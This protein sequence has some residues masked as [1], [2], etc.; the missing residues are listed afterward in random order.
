MTSGWKAS[1]RWNPGAA[2]VRTFHG[3]RR[4]RGFLQDG[5]RVGASVAPLAAQILALVAPDDAKV[6]VLVVMGYICRRGVLLDGHMCLG[7]AWYLILKAFSA[8]SQG[9]FFILFRENKHL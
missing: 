4:D 6:R 7:R 1:A 2:G 8:A 3:A 9:P 5:C